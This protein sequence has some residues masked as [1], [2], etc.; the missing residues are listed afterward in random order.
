MKQFLAI[1][2]QRRAVPRSSSFSVSSFRFSTRQQRSRGGSTGCSPGG[3]S[4]CSRSGRPRSPRSRSQRRLRALRSADISAFHRGGY[5]VAS[6]SL[7]FV[8]A[9]RLASFALDAIAIASALATHRISPRAAARARRGA[10]NEGAMKA[11]PVSRGGHP[12]GH[13]CGHP[14]GHLALRRKGGFVAALRRLRGRRL[15]DI[16]TSPLVR[17]KGVGHPRHRYRSALLLAPLAPGAIAIASALAS[18]RLS[19][20]PLPRCVCDDA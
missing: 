18:Q 13:L 11:R 15:A 16:P 8:P 19:D 17:C 14:S 20:Q 10:R 3:S 5:T 4:G 9:S 6:I 12:S 7:L 1:L 2:M